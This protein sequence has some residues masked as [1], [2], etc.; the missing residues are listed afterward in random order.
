MGG[1][2][3]KA[4]GDQGKPTAGQSGNAGGGASEGVKAARGPTR[5]EQWRMHVENEHVPHRRDCRVCMEAAGRA[6][7]RRRI[8]APNAFVMSVDI[9]RPDPRRWGPRRCE[10]KVRGGH[11]PHGAGEE[12]VWRT[13]GH[14]GRRGR[15]RRSRRR[16]FR[17][18]S[19]REEELPR[20]PEELPVEEEDLFVEQEERGSAP[21][22]E[23]RVEVEKAEEE[24]R[25]W[26]EKIKDLEDVAVRNLT[27]AIPI[28]SRNR[29]VVLQAVAGCYS[30][31]RAAG[32]QVLRVHTDRAREF[33]C[34]AFRAWAAERGLWRTVTAG[35]EPQANGRC[36]N[37]VGVIKGRTKVL[38]E[39]SGAPKEKW[40]LA[41]RH[42]AELRW[43]SQM[44]ALGVPQL[45]LVPFGSRAMVKV[46][47]WRKDRDWPQKFEPVQVWGPSKDMAQGY[48][49]ECEDGCFVRAAAV[50]VTVSEQ[51][52][53]EER[54]GG[55]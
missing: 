35:D 11:G 13:T 19:R 27:F 15:S 28:R 53:E 5:D 29:D 30:R 49:V 12:V 10:G 23:G 44:R 36:E 33:T 22:E 7:A 14:A 55:A 48:Y 51:V 41:L 6:G 20:G 2:G 18:T 54:H 4:E 46:K 31:Y 21:G 50:V 3:T 17:P 16:G 1:M 45:P 37:E 39:A 9:L 47:R 32:L 40:P 42:A 34:A 24:T 52:A 26:K 8:R 25:K 43:R 38:L